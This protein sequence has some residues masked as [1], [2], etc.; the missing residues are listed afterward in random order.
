METPSVPD[1]RRRAET[2]RERRE[3]D[4]VAAA[5]IDAVVRDFADRVPPDPS[6]PVGAVYARF[7]SR[8]QHSLPDQVRAS[9]EAAAL[10]NVRVPRDLVFFDRAVRGCRNRRPGLDRL[11][12]ALADR[13][14]AVLIA[15]S[16]NRLFRKT[17]MALKFVEEEAVERGVRV[18]F[19][20]SGID[21]ADADHWRMLLN[22]HA[23]TDEMMSGMNAAHIRS[24]HQGIFAERGV[25][26]TVTFGYRGV[27][28]DGRLTRRNRE[29]RRIEID[30]ETA[31]WVRRIFAWFVDDGLSLRAII[32]R[33]NDDPEIPLGPKSSSA[34]WTYSAL[35]TLLRNPRYRGLWEYG[36][37]ANVWL[38][39]KDYSR[40]VLRPA[41][42]KSM[43]IEALRIVD[44]ATWYAAQARRVGEQRRSAGRKAGKGRRPPQPRLLNGLF[45]CPEHDRPLLVAGSNGQYLNCPTCND[46][47][48][49]ARAIYSV[50]DRSVAQRRTC[51][52]LADLVRGDDPLVGSVVAACRAEAASLQRPEPGGQRAAT[53]RVASLT[54]QIDFVLANAGE[55]DRDRVEAGAKLVAL[56]GERAR[57]EAEIAQA[58]A[59]RTR[60]IAVPSEAEVCVLIDRL[61]EILDAA[62]R[63]DLGD[64]E[65][66]R[67]RQV[68]DLLTGGRVDLFQMGERRSHGG[69][70]QARFR[71]RLISGLVAE[72]AGSPLA[73]DEAD[74]ATEATI[75]FREP[76]SA[77]ARA[78]RVKEMYDAGI[79]IKAIEAELG[80]PRC[81]AAKA[82]K[83]W[84][85][86]RGL[87]PP[88]GRGRRAGLVQ[89]RTGP[90]KAERIADEVA[91]LSD[92]G[93]LF[94]EIATRLGCHR[95]LI[96]AATAHWH[97][98]R[99]L[100]VPDGRS[101]RK[102]L[103][104]RSRSA[105][106]PHLDSDRVADASAS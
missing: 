17:Y 99:G 16:T 68:V 81:S 62:G 84:H 34:R 87:A 31:P 33:L 66:A 47:P 94:A 1:F 26:G 76:S 3:F 8:F 24:A 63:S 75:D 46:L 61:A 74:A 53:A 102:T 12:D 57:L 5:E 21:T 85:R 30:P 96:T 56:R 35:T 43:R 92:E 103:P 59:A 82:L 25:V 2:A 29:R 64:L 105:A 91:R 104:R 11:R 4:D 97:R 98:L 52:V 36:R 9:L 40:Q 27:A 6:A 23:M 45:R 78:D 67:A 41:A 101:R 100:P 71:P 65:T 28:V 106:D 89:K 60:A 55:S 95:D 10:K 70:L 77:E 58:A 7:S 39:Q 49:S 38:A 44:D 73:A 54:A 88:D 83:F 80:L 72:L 51:E 32:H 14:V 19:V 20:A 37:T 42:L 69:W 50:L 90:S 86:N 15:F 48:A 79:L 13:R 22:V 93:L 18:L